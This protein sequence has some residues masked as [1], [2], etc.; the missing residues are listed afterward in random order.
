M[1]S[2]IYCVLYRMVQRNTVKLALLY[3][4]VM[5]EIVSLHRKYNRNLD[6]CFRSFS[7]VSSSWYIVLSSAVRYCMLRNLNKRKLIF[8]TYIIYRLIVYDRYNV[9]SVSC[10]SYLYFYCTQLNNWY[11]LCYYSFVLYRSVGLNINQY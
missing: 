9:P 6:N 2:S 1:L 8:P 7:V 4:V 11:V 5:K 3:T 10:S